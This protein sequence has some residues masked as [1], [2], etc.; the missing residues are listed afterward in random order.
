MELLQGSMLTKISEG[1]L[2]S[3][4]PPTANHFELVFPSKFEHPKH[5]LFHMQKKKQSVRSA[6]CCLVLQILLSMME[7]YQI[8]Q[9]NNS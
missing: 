6:I 9:L 1:L 2:D 7:C 3:D 4:N 8:K 5:V